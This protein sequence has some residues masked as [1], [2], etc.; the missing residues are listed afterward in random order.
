EFR[1]LQHLELVCLD[2]RDQR[3]R[4]PVHDR[5][6][7][8]LQVTV[9]WR[10]VDAVALLAGTESH[11]ED[12]AVGQRDLGDLERVR[13]AGAWK[14]LHAEERTTAA[15][16]LGLAPSP[17]NPRAPPPRWPRRRAG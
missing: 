14:R 6:Q 17:F 16:G 3:G 10:A 2:Q 1:H 5:L 15:A 12:P 13:E 11:A 9:P 8:G 7:V 4:A